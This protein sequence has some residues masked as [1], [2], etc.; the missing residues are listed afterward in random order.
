MNLVKLTYFSLIIFLCGNVSAIE[1]SSLP[2]KI[3]DKYAGGAAG[4]RAQCPFCGQYY[5]IGSGHRCPTKKKG[6]QPDKK[7][8]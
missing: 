6:D 7:K 4:M 8:K 5:L 3:E 2:F 1:Q